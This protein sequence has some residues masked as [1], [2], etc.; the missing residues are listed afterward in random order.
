M[1]LKA[2]TGEKLFAHMLSYEIIY[3][4]NKSCEILSR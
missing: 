2:R 3:N 4:F 1:N